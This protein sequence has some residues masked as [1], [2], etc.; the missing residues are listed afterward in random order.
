[1]RL[2]GVDRLA[3]HQLQFHADDF[4]ED[5]VVMIEKVRLLEFEWV[6]CEEYIYISAGDLQLQTSTLR[7]LQQHLYLGDVVDGKLQFR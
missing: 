5:K 4:G 1:M 7:T 6:D 3:P 2:V